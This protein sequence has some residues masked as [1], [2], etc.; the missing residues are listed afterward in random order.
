MPVS[1]YIRRTGK[2]LTYTIEYD[3]GEYFIHRDGAMKKSF[4]DAMTSG[5]SP[6]EATPDLMLKLAIG[7]IETLNGMEE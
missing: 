7:D 6:K 5:I 3:R 1:E 4:P 2:R